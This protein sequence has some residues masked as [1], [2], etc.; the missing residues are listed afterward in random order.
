[1]AKAGDIIVRNLGHAGRGGAIE[2]A[3]VV[4]AA[5]N[6]PCRSRDNGDSSNCHRA[7]AA[8]QQIEQANAM[9][10]AKAQEPAGM[11]QQGWSRARVSCG[12]SRFDPRGHASGC[13]WKSNLLRPRSR[14]LEIN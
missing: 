1:M 5:R 3:E 8:V 10:D 7:Q 2:A 4:P 9:L 6:P 13:R 14:R 12:Q 11:Q